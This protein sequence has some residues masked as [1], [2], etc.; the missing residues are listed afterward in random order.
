MRVRKIPS[1]YFELLEGV[2]IITGS[3]TLQIRLED[4][5]SAQ[6]REGK[7]ILL[8]S[9]PYGVFECAYRQDGEVQQRRMFFRAAEIENMRALC[10]S[11][12]QSLSASNAA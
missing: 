5:E 6:C 1:G 4:I 12:Q 9:T 3:E 2:L 10:S 8:P 11:I 7:K